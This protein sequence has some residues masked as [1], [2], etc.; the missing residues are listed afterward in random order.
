MA[1]SDIALTELR[2]EVAALGTTVESAIAFIDG[3][4]AQL[5]EVADDPD[6]VRAVIASL[7]NQRETLAQAIATTPENPNPDVPPTPDPN[8][9]PAEPVA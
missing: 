6:E 4:T 3:L 5:T 2:D 8:A 9:P 1:A 7:R